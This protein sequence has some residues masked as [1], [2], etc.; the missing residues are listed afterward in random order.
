MAIEDLPTLAQLQ[1]TPRATPKHEL[2]TRLDRA[3]DHKAARL[4]DAKQ[5]RTW[6]REV[7]TL[8]HWKDRKTGRRVLRTLSLDPD[9][10][11]SHHVESRDDW[12]V[13]YDVRNG[14]CLSLATH[15]A[16]TR[17][18][19]AIEGTVFFTVKGQRYINARFP[20]IFVRT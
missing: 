7:K 19:L 12:A 16:I 17:G 11:E 18:Q 9:R 14:I 8:D 13:R 10:A 20:V 4:L 5:L 2:E 6:A 15:D 3:I 1:A